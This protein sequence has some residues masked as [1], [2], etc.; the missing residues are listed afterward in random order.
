M[1]KAIYCNYSP[2]QLK[3]GPLSFLKS[4]NEK[5]P[6]VS[7]KETSK[8]CLKPLKESKQ[9]EEIFS[10]NTYASFSTIN[11]PFDIHATITS[12]ANTEGFRDPSIQ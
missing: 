8:H 1:T 3:I 6:R 10:R 2:S 9:R 4:Y 7:E 11:R 5:G 12:F